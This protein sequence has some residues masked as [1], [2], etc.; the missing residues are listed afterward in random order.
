MSSYEFKEWLNFSE[1]AQYL[2]DK[3]GK[4]YDIN[5]IHRAAARELIRAHYWPTDDAEL[6]VFSIVYDEEKSKSLP[7]F[8]VRNVESAIPIRLD[9]LELLFQ[10]QGPIPITHYEVFADNSRARHRKPVGITVQL[11]SE[12]DEIF[13]IGGCYRVDADGKAVGL[14]DGDYDFF[15]HVTELEELVTA[16][17]NA[18]E[19]PPLPCKL[20]VI[21][22]SEDENFEDLTYI[23]SS[24]PYIRYPETED[25]EPGKSNNNI[26]KTPKRPEPLLKTIGFAAYL[27]AEL[28]D[29]LDQF[30]TTATHKKGL[31]CGGKPNCSSISK[32]LSRIA[33]THN[34]DLKSDGFY[35]NLSAALKHLLP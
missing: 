16:I 11:L 18:P 14:N 17:P 34:Y 6:G 33:A 27:I 4:K 9:K 23:H 13:E 5:A 10:F 28:G 32:E 12:N 21:K 3:T 26:S 20:E 22:F 15:V 31:S 30:Q 35:K 24:A 1:A 2:S 29:K 19:L 7:S 25:I 8:I